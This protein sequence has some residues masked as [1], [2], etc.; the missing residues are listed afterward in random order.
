MDLGLKG[1]RALVTAASRGLG[2]AT[3]TALA[4]EGAKVALGARNATRLEA[5]AGDLARS[6]AEALPV[7]MDLASTESIARAVALLRERWGGL[8]ILVVNTPG[9]EAGP[10]LSLD[11]QAWQR[12]LDTVLMPVIDVLH[13]A[14]PDMRRA[15]GRVLLIT[16]VGVKVVQPAMVLSSAIRLALTGIAKTLS[17]ELAPDN[18]LVNCL[19]PGPIDTDRMTDLIHA[20]SRQR[21][22]SQ[23]EAE[24]IWLDEVPLRR[25]GRV[26]DFGKLAAVLV[27]DAAS[28]VTGAAL[29]VDGGKSRAY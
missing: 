1:K 14:L 27:S 25:M 26:E 10:F 19:C 20:T 3:A 17:V 7:E 29:Q 13:A 24:A 15:G 6:G 8:D 22:I 11:R 21:N 5:A 23:A 12:A 16:T 18:V 28:Y 2:F 4:A 9:P